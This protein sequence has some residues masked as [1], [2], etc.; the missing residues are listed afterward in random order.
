MVELWAERQYVDAVEDP[1]A[2]QIWLGGVGKTLLYDR[3]TMDWLFT[4]PSEEQSWELALFGNPKPSES[5]GPAKSW[6]F[7][8]RSPASVETLVEKGL[9]KKGWSERKTTCC[10]H[11]KIENKVQEKNR[12]KQPWYEVCDEYSMANGAEAPYKLSKTEYL[13]RLADSKFG[14]CLAGFGKKCHREIECMAMGCVPVCAPE[15]DMENY[16]SPPQ[17]GVH[18]I[19]VESP[20]DAKQKLATMTEEQWRLMS[21]ACM[22]WWKENASAEGSWRLTAQLAGC[23]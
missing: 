18:Y 10:F 21:V 13:L 6:F 22:Q 3:P 16:A 5:G 1:K 14:L 11:G 8:P 15:V 2:V 7:W 17:E 20:E 23:K 9:A 4:A 19:R 12:V